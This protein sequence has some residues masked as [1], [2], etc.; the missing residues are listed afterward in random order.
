[1]LVEQ[2]ICRKL[3]DI[4]REALP[5]V[6]VEGNWLPSDDG[7]FKGEPD[8]EGSV[9]HVRVGQRG[10][11]SYTNKV[12]EFKVDID[13]T[14]RVEEDTDMTGT[15]VACGKILGILSGWQDDIAAVK[16]DLTVG[17]SE[18]ARGESEGEPLTSNLLPHFPP[19]A[20]SSA[21]TATSTSSPRLSPASSTIH[22]PSKEG[23]TK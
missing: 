11:T 4:F 10:Y 8:V 22:S 7:G 23:S 9:L 14:I 17:K 16:R 3:V 15:F 20:I 13:G 19:S 6:E 12:A 2:L 21:R 1:M 5:G 18:E